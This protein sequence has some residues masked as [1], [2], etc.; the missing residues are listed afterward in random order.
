[1]IDD[2]AHDGAGPSMS[3]MWQENLVGVTKIFIILSMAYLLTWE[4]FGH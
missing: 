3:C 2:G 4:E 1:M